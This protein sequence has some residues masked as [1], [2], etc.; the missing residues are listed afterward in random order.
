MCYQENLKI[1]GDN[2]KAEYKLFEKCDKRQYNEFAAY[3]KEYLTAE[4]FYTLQEMIAIY[5]SPLLKW[6]R[7][8]EWIGRQQTPIMLKAN[9]LEQTEQAVYTALEK[10]KKIDI[11]A[12]IEKVLQAHREKLI[13]RSADLQAIK[14]QTA[15]APSSSTKGTQGEI[16]RKGAS[17]NEQT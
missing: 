5:N 3:I 9:F 10:R 16:T 1:A 7:F 14:R 4:Q 12:E 11:L 8:K 17:K 15:P 13:K 6:E 2:L